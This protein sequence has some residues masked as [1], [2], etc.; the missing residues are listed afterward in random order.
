MNTTLY[1]VRNPVSLTSHW[2]PT[3]DP[4]MPLVRVWTDANAPQTDNTAPSTDELGRML[5]CA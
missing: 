1:L 5:L 4:R 3:D 2:E